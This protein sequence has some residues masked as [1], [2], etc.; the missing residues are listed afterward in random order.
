MNIKVSVVILSYNTKELTLNCLLSIAKYTKKIAYEVV[1]VDNNSTDGSPVAIQRLKGKVK[2]LTLIKSKENLGFSR[3]NNLGIKKAKGQYILLL[4]SDTVLKENSIEKM[5]EWMDKNQ[6]VGI[7]TCKLVGSNGKIQ[8]NG[9]H[10]PTLLRVFSWMSIE[11]IPGVIKIIRPF[12]PLQEKWILRD[13][14]VYQNYWEPDWVTGAF[15]MIRRETLSQIGVLDEDYFMYTE[16][17]DYCYRAKKADWKVA[18]VPKTSI[19]HYGGASSTK[20]FPVLSEYKGVKTFYKKHYP[21]WQYPFLRFLLKIGAF[22]RMV[23]FGLIEGKETAAVYA[24][25]LRQA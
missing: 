22:G 1:V 20:E 16:D 15:F 17:T 8:G 24:K 10:F 19:L 25:A 12:H 13:D 18:Y 5:A 14:S 9:G 3:G 6:K 7:S 2:N 4:N 11:D 21:A 23:L